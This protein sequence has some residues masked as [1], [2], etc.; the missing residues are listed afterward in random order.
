[1]TKDDFIKAQNL[2][3]GIE[4]TRRVV[5]AYVGTQQFSF[6]RGYVLTQMMSFISR[7]QMK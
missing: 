6:N 2:F 7:M 3:I 4:S 1:M 5:G